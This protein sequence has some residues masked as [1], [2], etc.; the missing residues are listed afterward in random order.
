MKTK[1]KPDKY[2]VPSLARAFEILDILGMSSVGMT[3][4]EIARNIG[5]PYSTAFNLLNTMEQHGYV[6]KDEATFIAAG[7]GRIVARGWQSLYQRNR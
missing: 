1:K 3:K 4:M 6:R 7:H 2:T 5:I